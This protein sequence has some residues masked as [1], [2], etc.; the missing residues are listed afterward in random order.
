MARTFFLDERSVTGTENAVMAAVLARGTTILCNVASEP[1]V[2]ELC[3]MLNAMGAQ[4]SG[5]GTNEMVIEGVS[6]LSGTTHTIGPDYMEVG[7][8]IGLA[9]GHQQRTPHRQCRAQKHA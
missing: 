3:F 9:G 4:I 6:K 2:Q 8:F 1:H 5:I 7:S